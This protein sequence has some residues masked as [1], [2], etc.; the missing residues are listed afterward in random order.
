[1][2]RV[3]NSRRHPLACASGAAL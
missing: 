2:E 3:W 1:L